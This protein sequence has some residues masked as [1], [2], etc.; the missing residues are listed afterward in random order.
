MIIEDP[1]TA[2]V[3]LF[4][5]PTLILVISLGNVIVFLCAL[6]HRKLLGKLGLIFLFKDI[7]IVFVHFSNYNT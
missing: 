5:L 6:A 1:I 7:F 3:F 4:L 2:K